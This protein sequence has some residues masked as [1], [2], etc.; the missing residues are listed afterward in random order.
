MQGLHW[1]V[2]CLV[3]VQANYKPYA[4]AYII[5]L[6]NLH[7]REYVATTERHALFMYIVCIQNREH[8]IVSPQDHLLMCVDGECETRPQHSHVYTHTSFTVLLSDTWPT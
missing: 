8:R 3:Q 2:S 7:Y 5:E 6:V 1:L 4:K